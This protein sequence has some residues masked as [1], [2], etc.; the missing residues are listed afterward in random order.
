[1]A[2]TVRAI[3]SLRLAIPIF[4][5]LPIASSQDAVGPMRLASPNRQL[6]VTFQLGE[7]DLPTFDVRYGEISVAA[8]ELGLAAIPLGPS[9]E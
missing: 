3:C 7:R 6:R 9:S 2:A 8:G 5:F 1:M 4:L